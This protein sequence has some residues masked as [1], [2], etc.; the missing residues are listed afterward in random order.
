MKCTVSKFC[1]SIW[2]V[3]MNIFIKFYFQ[4]RLGHLKVNKFTVVVEAALI[5]IFKRKTYCCCFARNTLFLR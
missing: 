2:C 1:V 5:H 3:Q 4:N